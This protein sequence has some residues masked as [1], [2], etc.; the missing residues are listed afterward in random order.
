[1]FSDGLAMRSDRIAKRA[2][3]GE[4]AGSHSVG[5][6]RKRW[7]DSM[8]DCLKDVRQ[9]RRMAHDRIVWRRFVRVNER[10]S[11]RGRTLEF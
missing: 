1:M 5:R 7:I 9:S 4:C 10:V 8:N 6:T 3:V 11:L 2:Y